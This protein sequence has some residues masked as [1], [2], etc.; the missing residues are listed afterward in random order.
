MMSLIVSLLSSLGLKFLSYRKD[1]TLAKIKK[2]GDKDANLHKEKLAKI[3][4]SIKRVE[5]WGLQNRD[6]NKYFSL[7]VSKS[8]IFLSVAMWVFV[9]SFNQ[10][11]KDLLD[12]QWKVYT[13]DSWTYI[14]MSVIAYMTLTEM[15]DS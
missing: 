5:Q 1:I 9:L 6:D 13:V 3:D 4:A 2:A 11:F 7:R 15:K 10:S 12:L 8:I 14:V